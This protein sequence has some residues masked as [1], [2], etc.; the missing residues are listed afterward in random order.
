MISLLNNQVHVYVVFYNS[1]AEEI[2][3][4]NGSHY[5]FSE[6]TCPALAQVYHDLHTKKKAKDD[7]IENEDYEKFKQWMESS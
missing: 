2:K 7:R 5:S 4:T 1:K 3:D 6:K